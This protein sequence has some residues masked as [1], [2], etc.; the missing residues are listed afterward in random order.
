LLKFFS[1]IFLSCII[2]QT[3]AAQDSTRYS[4]RAWTWLATQTL[5]N[6][7]LMHDGNE[8]EGRLI[9]TLR[10]QIIPLNI[11]FHA[12]KY[13]SPAQFFYINPVRKF[14]GSIELFVQPELSLAS[15]NY[16]NMSRFGLAT[17]SRITIPIKEQGEHMAISIGGKY[18]FRKDEIGDNNGYWGV[19]AGTY[20]FFDMI[21]M[22]FNY[23]FD[24]RTRYN[25]GIYI[26]LF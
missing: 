14:T 17:G 20:F 23:N 24:K 16:G 2:A 15:F 19:E 12:N 6:P 8:T 21:G 26:K 9:T 5:P 25:I 7:V 1:I 3:A 18:T 22:Q 4:L 11:S 10:W 13:V